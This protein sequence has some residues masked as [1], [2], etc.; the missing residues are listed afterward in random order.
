MSDIFKKT[1]S[2]QEPEKRPSVPSSKSASKKPAAA[3]KRPVKKQRRW[4][5][6]TPDALIGG[7]AMDAAA[8]M[9]REVKG[10]ERFPVW[11]SDLQS[12]IAVAQGTG[13]DRPYE[14]VH[15]ILESAKALPKLCFFV[16]TKEE[17]DI[18]VVT[19]GEGVKTLRFYADEAL[20]FCI[21][22]N[23]RF[24]CTKAFLKSKSNILP[25]RFRK[26]SSGKK[27]LYLH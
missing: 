19:F 12:R 2:K 16:E 14:F 21:A 9:F 15:K 11:L 22:N 3:K 7:R 27:P 26:K 4:I 5:E 13:G 17:R 25:S 1:L 8:M 6:V 23:C 20:V 18:V 10:E 24:F